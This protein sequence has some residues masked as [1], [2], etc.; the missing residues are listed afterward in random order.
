[1]NC[2][3][4]FIE[5]Y[6]GET[7]DTLFSCVYGDVQDNRFDVIDRTFS[8]RI[9]SSGTVFFYPDK[10]EDECGKE[11]VITYRDGDWNGS[12]ILDYGEEIQPIKHKQMIRHCVPDVDRIRTE[13]LLKGLSEE[14][15]QK[16]I[17]LHGKKVELL[18]D[19]IDDM[20]RKH[21][22]DAYF[23]PTNKTDNYYEKYLKDNYLKVEWEEIEE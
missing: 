15:I 18:K 6:G 13:G 8:N 16:Q 20:T 4:E 17:K 22:Y 2:N 21:N 10:N 5:E 14:E 12:E 19:K 1:M 3:E 23:S 9:N 11:I 7:F